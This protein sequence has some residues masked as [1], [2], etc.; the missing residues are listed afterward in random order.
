MA[1]SK[2]LTSENPASKEDLQ[3]LLVV[4]KEMEKRGIDVDDIV[5]PFLEE[6]SDSSWNIDETGYFLKRDGT[7]FVPNSPRQE[8][9]VSSNARFVALF[10]GRGGGF[11]PPGQWQGARADEARQDHWSAVNGSV[12][13]GRPSW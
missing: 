5:V 9:F 12:S 2:F 6:G 13:S 10:S 8:A 11:Q 4:L 3:E 1:K 7:T